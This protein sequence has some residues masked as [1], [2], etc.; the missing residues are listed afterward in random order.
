MARIVLDQVSLLFPILHLDHWSFKKSLLSTATGGTIMRTSHK[1]PTVVALDKIS[2]H[3]TAGDRVGLIGANG[4]GKSTL[5]R[6]IAGIYEPSEGSVEVS[7]TILPILDIGVGFN[8]NMTG[9]ENI[10]MQGMYL[11]YRPAAME[12]VAGEIEEFTELGNYL[13]LPVRTYSAG[14]Q[15][16]LSLGVATAMRPDILLMD[17][18]LLAGDAAFLS[19]ARERLEKFVANASILFI[20]SH[21]ESIIRQWCNKAI[22]LKGGKIACCG[23]VDEA[24]DA[25]QHDVL[26]QV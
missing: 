2:G 8:P 25:Y 13:D 14:M 21:S 11:G 10:R 22:Y 6:I 9:R 20:A 23:T 15:M 7:G 17:E 12:R 18:W 19:K 24:M 1:I 16:R 26:H 4:A 5:L 3:F